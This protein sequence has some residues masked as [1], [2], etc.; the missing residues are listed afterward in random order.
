[1]T[2]RNCILRPV[3]L[4]TGLLCIVWICVAYSYY[5]HGGLIAPHVKFALGIHDGTLRILHPGIFWL[6]SG[7]S[8]LSGLPVL[9]SL[10]WL[11]SLHVALTLCAL[12]F[13]LRLLAPDTNEWMLFISA[14]LLMVVSH[15]GFF[16]LDPSVYNFLPYHRNFIILRNATHTAM[17]PYAF[18]AFGLL[19]AVIK[20]HLDKNPYNQKQG[21]LC[22]VFLFAATLIKPSFCITL[23]PAVVLYLLAVYHADKKF[24][25]H[26]ALI[27]LPTALLLALQFYVGFVENPQGKVIGMGVDPWRVWA[28][29]NHQPILSLF[30]ALAFPLWIACYRGK[31]FS[32]FTRIAW[33]N[34]AISLVPYILLYETNNDRDFEWSHLHAKQIVFLCSVVEWWGWRKGA[35]STQKWPI[36][37]G[38]ALF[39][40]HAMFGL[41]KLMTVDLAILR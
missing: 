4:A 26:M 3:T 14:A 41:V 8:N 9:E 16:G 31:Q 23:I 2:A 13:A 5:Q 33:I 17:L 10:Y 29:N 39:L 25:V 36:M 35:A 7:F 18:V 34:L 38:A 1:M 6:A 19:C 37:I 30:L 22:G 24:L 21:L 11:L 28:W 20:N 15:I 12:I 27:F 32:F 40:A